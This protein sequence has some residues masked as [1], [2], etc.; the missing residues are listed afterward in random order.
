MSD[1][2]VFPD[3]EAAL[4]AH[5]LTV[6]ELTA[7]VGTRIFAEAPPGTAYPVLTLRKLSSRTL[8]VRW[9]ETVTIEVAGESHR[10][11]AG[12]RS[13]ARLVAETGVA[14]LNALSNRTV[15]RCVIAGPVATVGPRPVP[16]V[17]ATGVT[18]PRFIAEVTLTYHPE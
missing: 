10:D 18:N 7:L 15:E 5:C 16:D 3:I 14:V 9:L 13:E 6:P 17:L 2:L 8:Q 1:I 4:I 12:A 11:V